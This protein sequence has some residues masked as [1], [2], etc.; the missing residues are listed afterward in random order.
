[1][2]ELLPAVNGTM[3]R[4]GRSGQ[5]ASLDCACVRS[6][7]STPTKTASARRVI[8]RSPQADI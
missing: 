1:M 2:S 7:H 3:S 8:V 4:I 5:R 6:V